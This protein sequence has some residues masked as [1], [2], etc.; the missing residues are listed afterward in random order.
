M[1]QVIRNGKVHENMHLEE[2]QKYINRSK[3]WGGEYV[4]TLNMLDVEDNDWGISYEEAL[5][6]CQWMAERNQEVGMVAVAPECPEVA[7][8]E[9]VEVEEVAEVETGSDAFDKVIADALTGENSGETGETGKVEGAAPLVTLFNQLK[10]ATT[11]TVMDLREFEAC[12]GSN[13][14][15]Y[16][17]WNEY[18]KTNDGWVVK[19][20]T[21][22]EMVEQE[23]F[24]VTSFRTVWRDVRNALHEIESYPGIDF[25]VWIDSRKIA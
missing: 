8:V 19:G 22:C 5:V 14:G 3:R 7:E 2:I 15:S 21:S 25:R 10:D 16:A 20:G 23:E 4:I 9:T 24:E 12:R 18:K 1:W 6:D 17:F 11:V 13:G